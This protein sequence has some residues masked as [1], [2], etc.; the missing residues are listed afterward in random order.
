[1]DLSILIP[2]RNEMFLYKTVDN[3][4]ETIEGDTEIIIVADGNWPI[5]PVKDDPRVK[6]IYHSK[7]IGQRAATNEA[8][9]L[10]FAKF[11]M[12]CDAHCSFDK[13]F[14]VKLMQD[15]QHDWTM[16]P[17]QYNLHAFDWVCKCGNR[18]YQGPTPDKCEKCGEKMEREI[19]WERRPHTSNDFFYFDKEL[20][21]QYWNDYKERVS[22]KEELVETMS[23]LGACWMMH[24]D[25][26]WEL[27]GCDEAHGS[28]G[29]MGTEIACKTW[30][31]GGRLIV[32][33]KTWFAHMFRTQGGDFGFPYPNPGVRA[34]RNRSQEL[35]VKNKWDK[36]KY[37]LSWLIDKFAP[38]PTWEKKEVTKPSPKGM[39]YYTD[40]RPDPKLLE[41]VRKQISK[42]AN[43]HK[44]VSVTLK[45]T[46]F[47]KNIVLPLE[48]GYLTMF[49]QILAGIEAC[50]S[51][52]IFLVEHDV[53]YHPS[54]FEF[55]PPR[56]D[57]FYYDENRWF[58]D[59]NDGKALFYNAKST[60][61]LCAYRELLLEHYRKRVERVEKEGFSYRLGF[62]PGNH[63]YPR[64]VD[65]YTSEAWMAPFPSIDIRH[66]KN[67]TIT[68]WT[69]DGFRNKKNLYAWKEA[70]EVP[71][72]GR[73]K[74]RFQE[75]MNAI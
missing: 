24:R 4:L 3:I 55:T 67:L 27:D 65:N 56:K 64:G 45:P 26:F 21:F 74:G 18:K 51:E 38:V 72:W 14:D 34:A 17:R 7:S 62:E 1:M 5:P 52:I 12:K 66:E 73:T 20:H 44:I 6:M 54:H 37:P 30:L 70:D 8:A 63:P 41:I 50:D 42:C 29:Q 13:G 60:S 31:S 71:G 16:V 46:E 9:K 57:V 10:S 32:S 59:A 35:W 23:L 61:M 68:R 40:N 2:A 33:R 48:R 69:K 19:L 49:K 47:G 43:G 15:C 58:V 53:L 28:W 25:R 11:I 39:V 22:K 36:T 75:I